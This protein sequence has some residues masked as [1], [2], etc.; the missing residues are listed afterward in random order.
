MTVALFSLVDSQQEKLAK[1]ETRLGEIINAKLLLR[2][3]PG[4]PAI[5]F[6]QH[7]PSGNLQD[8]C[9]LKVVDTLAVAKLQEANACSDVEVP[10][11]IALAFGKC[12]AELLANLCGFDV[13]YIEGAIC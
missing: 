2:D 5:A 3:R 6:R 1:R 12:V 8:S 10:H 13:L 7:G 9:E 4:R 11:D